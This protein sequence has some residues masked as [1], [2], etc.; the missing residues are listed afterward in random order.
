MSIVKL[1]PD[2]S[3]YVQLR[4]VRSCSQASTET[5]MANLLPI[6][7]CA[8]LSLLA[9]GARPASCYAP[10]SPVIGVLTYPSENTDAVAR[11]CRKSKHHTCLRAVRVAESAMGPQS[12]Y[13]ESG[14]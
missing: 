3:S 4:F 13:I 8:L 2:R 7:R 14:Y 1:I 11:E 10:S 9:L 6:I 5:T 12:S